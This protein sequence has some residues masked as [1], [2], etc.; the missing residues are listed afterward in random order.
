MINAFM[1]FG[2][3]DILARLTYSAYL[4]H[5]II[6]GIAYFNSSQYYHYDAIQVALK[7]LAFAV[8]SFFVSMM[9]FLLV[10]RPMM[11]LE[12]L[13]LPHGERAERKPKQEQIN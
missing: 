8:I 10:E 4:Y 1:S 9:S 13:F 11:S 3:W 2:L 6:I 5:P 7:F 12:K